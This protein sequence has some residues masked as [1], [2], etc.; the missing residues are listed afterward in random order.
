MRQ[1]ARCV[2]MGSHLPIRKPR[3]T[4]SAT[5]IVG[6]KRSTA[7]RRAG[8]SETR[9]GFA[10]RTLWA[11]AKGKTRQTK[12]SGPR[13]KGGPD[14]IVTKYVF[15]Y[16]FFIARLMR[17]LH[18]LKRTADSLRFSSRPI[19]FA[20]FFPDSFLKSFTWAAFQ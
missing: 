17:S 2:R 11:P 15:D 13:S 7:R 10:G 5:K 9:I 19:A 8:S 6:R 3:K 18:A 1:R 4:P 14:A 16:Y 20:L 12:A